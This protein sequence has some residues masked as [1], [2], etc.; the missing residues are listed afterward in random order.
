MLKKI[1]CSILIFI[2]IGCSNYEIKNEDI[3]LKIESI[4]IN[5]KIEISSINKYVNGIV[6]FY[7]YGRPDNKFNTIIGAHSGYGDNA[8]FNNLSLIKEND[9]IEIT[10]YGDTYTYQTN[11]VYKV[12][13]N[14]VSILKNEEE[15]LL[16]LITCNIENIKERIIVKASKIPII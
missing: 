7:E 13:E 6:M 4:N 11:S 3:I 10:Y 1:L 8:Y 15:N 14:D 12:N 2:S 5:N 9:I 16:I